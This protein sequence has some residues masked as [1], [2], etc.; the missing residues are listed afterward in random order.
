VTDR[1]LK[2]TVSLDEGKWYNPDGDGIDNGGNTN[3]LTRDRMSPAGAFTGNTCLVQI[4][5]K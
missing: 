5:K 2:K 3:V 4:E 1:I